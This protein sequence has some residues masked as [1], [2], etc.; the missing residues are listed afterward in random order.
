MVPKKIAIVD[1]A[2]GCWSNPAIDISL[3]FVMS[4]TPEERKEKV[5]KELT[6]K[7]LRFSSWLML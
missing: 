2:T 6:F 3:F 7:I 1:F 4:L 5:I